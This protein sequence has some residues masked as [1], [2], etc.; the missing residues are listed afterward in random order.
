MRNILW[1]IVA[2]LSLTTLGIAATQAEQAGPSNHSGMS[3]TQSCP[4][5]VPGTDLSITDAEN[6]IALNITTKVGDVA[7]LRRRVENMAKM[8]SASSST[9]M[10]GNMMQFSVKYEEVASGARL[11]LTP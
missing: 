5:R 10:H 8:H 1:I 3:M 9:A 11:T 4:M 6:G 7:E 2:V